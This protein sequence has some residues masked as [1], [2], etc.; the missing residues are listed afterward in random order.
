M[1]LTRFQSASTDRTVTLNGVPAPWAVGVPVLPVT[2][3]GAAVSPGTN[4]CSFTKFPVLTVMDE[5]VLALLLPSV[6]SLAVSVRVP[7]V[8]SVTLKV[9]VPE[10][11]AAFGGNEVFASL[12]VIPTVSV[13][14]PITFQLA[15]TALTVTLNGVLAICVIGVPVLPVAVPGAAVSPGARICSFVNAPAL[16][17]TVLFAE[18]F[19]P[20]V[21]LLAVTVQLPAVLLVTPKV[22]V[23]EESAAFAGCVS[24]GSEVVMPMVLAGAEVTRFQLAST[25]RTVTVYP[26]PAV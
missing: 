12:E 16:T 3:P 9:C 20:S 14:V 26:M 24:F 25:A 11:S 2:V 13:A 17:V 18:V 22:L 23:P 4:S 21:T 5:L 6:M 8:L 15:S 19:V 1:L 7:A 10:T